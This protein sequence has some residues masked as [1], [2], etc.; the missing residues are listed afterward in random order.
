MFAQYIPPLE[1]AHEQ[2]YVTSFTLPV[3]TTFLDKQFFYP[4]SATTETNSPP[5]DGK[6]Q[7]NKRPIPRD[8][9]SNSSAIPPQPKPEWSQISTR[10]KTNFDENQIKSRRELNRISTR[11]KMNL[12]ENQTESRRESQAVAVGLKPNPSHIGGEVQCIYG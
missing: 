5:F 7:A 8:S 1:H 12:G 9:A 4:N 2:H 10:I 6:H 11:I 3:S